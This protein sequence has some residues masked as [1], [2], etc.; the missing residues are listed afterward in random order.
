MILTALCFGKLCILSLECT[1]TLHA[2]AV[3]KVLKIVYKARYTRIKIKNSNSERQV[4]IIS[5]YM[6]RCRVGK[7]SPDP[8]LNVYTFFTIV[9]VVMHERYDFVTR[10]HRVRDICIT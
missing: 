10:L 3:G 8:V 7:Q 1:I 2:K 9:C 6:T 4:G 5:V